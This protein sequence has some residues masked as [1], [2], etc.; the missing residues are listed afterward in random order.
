MS[1]KTFKYTRKAR[2][3][4]K[5][6]M[7]WKNCRQYEAISFWYDYILCNWLMACFTVLVNQNFWHNWSQTKNMQRTSLPFFWKFLKKCKTK[8]KTRFW[9]DIHY[10]INSLLKKTRDELW[11][12]VNP[13]RA[14]PTKGSKTLK[15][16]VSNSQRIVWVRWIVWVCLTIL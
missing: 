2:V 7:P 9:N 12:S 13:S 6:I 15:Q 8:K 3:Y 5:M 4:L 10:C 11:N 14:N 16:F 1:D